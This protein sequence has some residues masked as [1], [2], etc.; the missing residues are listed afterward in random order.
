[1]F[2]VKAY[3]DVFNLL[4]RYHTRQALKKKEIFGAY[5]VARWN[6]FVSSWESFAGE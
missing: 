6:H 3:E 4:G 2:T 1:M 5:Q